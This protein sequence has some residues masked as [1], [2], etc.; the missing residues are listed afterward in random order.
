MGHIQRRPL[1]NPEP[2]LTQGNRQQSYQGY[3]V[4]CYHFLYSS[5]LYFHGNENYKVGSVDST[6]LF[7]RN[8]FDAINFYIA[9]FV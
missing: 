1:A 4:T 2:N 8:A 9:V 6:E 5:R 3:Q 7:S